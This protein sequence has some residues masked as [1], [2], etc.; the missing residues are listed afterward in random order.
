MAKSKDPIKESEKAPEQT[1]EV[2]QPKEK[3]TSPTY[4][5]KYNIEELAEAAKTAFGT[6]RVIVLAALKDAGKEAYTMEEA[7]KIVKTFK[8]KEVK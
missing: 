6:H 8:T 3:P 2:E 5:T 7:E 4:I 1:K